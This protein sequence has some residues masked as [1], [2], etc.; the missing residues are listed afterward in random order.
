MCAGAPLQPTITAATGSAA[1]LSITIQQGADRT[2][3]DYSLFVPG[4]I[5]PFPIPILI[6]LIMGVQPSARQP[7]G[8]DHLTIALGSGSLPA[9]GRFILL[10]SD[11]RAAV[12]G[13]RVCGAPGG[14][15]GRLC[16]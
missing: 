5:G 13:L 4:Q 2:A 1:G 15:G 7:G 8:I 14:R 6:P 10:A 11:P 3:I 9:G 16:N 12:A